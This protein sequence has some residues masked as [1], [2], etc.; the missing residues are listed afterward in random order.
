MSKDARRFK[1]EKPRSLVNSI[2]SYQCVCCSGSHPLSKCEDFR[3]KTVAQRDDF[4]REHKL[5]FNCLRSGHFFPKY[6]SKFKCSHCRRSH[7]SLLHAAKNSMSSIPE[8]SSQVKA[9]ARPFVPS[10]S[11]ASTATGSIH[12]A[13]VQTVPP[14][15]MAPPNVLLATATFT[16]LK[17]EALRFVHYWIKNTLLVLFRSRSVRLC[18][19]K[20]DAPI[21][22]LNVSARS[23]RASPSPASRYKYRRAYRPS[24]SFR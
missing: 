1:G 5:C 21:Y 24:Q 23:S 19:L 3:Q 2:S 11:N 9:D 12:F 17:V 15:Y 10:A 13:N 6:S 7:H 4:A 8:N 20:D 22:S 18:V 16:R 14:P